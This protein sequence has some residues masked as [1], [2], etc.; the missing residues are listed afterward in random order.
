MLSFEVVK[1][2]H[3]AAVLHVNLIVSISANTATVC[4]GN[5]RPIAYYLGTAMSNSY[6]VEL[7]YVVI[8][9]AML[10]CKRVREEV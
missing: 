4:F 5:F 3:H 9:A 6:W 2:V 7:L 8:H 10:P 1:K